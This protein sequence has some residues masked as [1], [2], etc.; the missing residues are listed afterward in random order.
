MNALGRSDLYLKTEIIK[1]IFGLGVLAVSVLAFTTPLAIAWA[2]MLSAVFSMFVTMVVMKRLFAYR[3]RDQ[4][5]DMT[6]PVLLSAV[7]WGVVYAVSRIVLPEVV[8]LILQVVCGIAVY[9]GLA[10]LLKLESFTYL[11]NAMKSYFSK[12]RKTQ[13]QPR[14]PDDVCS[15]N[16][17]I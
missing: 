15:P 1:K 5:W 10:V 11:W 14:D 7:M 2:V 8:S 6:P 9:L 4:I 16:D 3:W 17:V 12:N 13:E